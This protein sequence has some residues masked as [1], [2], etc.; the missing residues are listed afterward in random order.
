MIWCEVVWCGV[1]VAWW[2]VEVGGRVAGG[3]VAGVVW[4]EVVGGGSAVRCGVRYGNIFR[5]ARCIGQGKVTDK[6]H[7]RP[8]APGKLGGVIG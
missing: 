1:V 2:G 3:R 4:W 6:T 8:T 5:R 7:K